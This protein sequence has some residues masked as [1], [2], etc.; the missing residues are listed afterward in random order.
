[1]ASEGG[2]HLECNRLEI[3]YHICYLNVLFAL[4]P[5]CPTVSCVGSVVLGS[6]RVCEV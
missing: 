5:N 6:V 3:R 2:G 1:M 4:W